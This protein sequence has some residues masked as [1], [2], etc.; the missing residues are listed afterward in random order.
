MCTISL[1]PV[2]AL[3]I[4][5]C[6]LC[7][8]SCT[9]ESETEITVSSIVLNELDLDLVVGE[10]AELTA[11][12]YPQDASDA[13]VTWSSSNTA[14]ATVDDGLVTA[15][16][17]GTATIKASAGGK[18]ASCTVTVSAATESDDD[19]DE[20]DDTDD[21]GSDDDADDS[22]DSGIDSGDD[23]GDADAGAYSQSSGN[24]SATGKTYISTSSDEN[25]VKVSGG[26]FTM[27]GCTVKKTGG[28]TSD[29]DGSSFYG[30][31]SAIL[32][33]G[34]GTVTM[35]G[36]TITTD[37]K[38]AN[39]VVAYQGTVNISD[40]TIN[41]SKSVSRGIHATGGGTIN[42]SNL[43]ITTNSET[44]SLIATDRGGG[45]VT[46]NGGTYTANG[47]KSAVCYSTGDITV[48]GITGSSAKGPMF[49]VEGSNSI[50]AKNSTLTSGGESRGILLHQSGSGDAS[51][52]NGAVYVTGGKLIYTVTDKPLIEVTT[53][54]TGTVELT[55][56][57]LDIASGILMAV[58]YT[59]H[60]NSTFAYL[61][62]LSE[63]S[64]VYTG[65]IVVDDTGTA[66]VTV[67]KGVTWKGSYDSDDSGKSTTV[68]V[69]GVWTLTGNSNVDSVTVA[70][71]G[72]INKNG[73]TLSY[74]SLSN[75]GSIN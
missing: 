26:S 33:T 40:V 45:T 37:A 11:T 52:T 59:K 25:A 10:T 67:G 31:N 66:T 43:T 4:A 55:D 54:M 30:I 23:S 38:G 46:V 71:G 58:D 47:K 61:N 48:T 24:Y 7:I 64:H 65:N 60:G 12:I 13:S 70:E 51:G 6:T 68:V 39:G 18:S 56:V 28:D 20:G 27:D 3:A 29:N 36:G 21:S 34:T 9:K 74:S 1:K 32:S 8:A 53:S 69:N 72:I 42:A 19:A 5:L 57:D 17:E 35:N 75:K 44:S 63:S 49:V 16:A 22:G 50:I 41:C 62:L 73:H 15:V 2:C 14:A